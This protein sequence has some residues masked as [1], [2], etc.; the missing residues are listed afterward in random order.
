MSK[1]K[2]KVVLPIL[3]LI[4]ANILWGVNYPMIKLGIATIPAVIFLTIRF[5]AI[6]VAS[7]VCR[8][9]MEATKAEGYIV[10]DIKLRYVDCFYRAD[11]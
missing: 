9:N 1:S 11:W 8:K 2:Q 4:F 6:S 3:A 5:F 7:A 10:D